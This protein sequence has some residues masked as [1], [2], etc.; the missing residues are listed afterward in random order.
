MKVYITARF[1]GSENKSEIEE[2][3]AAVKA[4]G[5]EDFCF[6]RDVENYQKTFDN[7]KDL[8]ERSKLEI[9]KCDALLI[10]VS[11]SPS[12][13]RVVEVGIAY[14]LGLPIFVIAKSGAEYKGFFD[15]VAT[16]VIRYKKY[17]DI[18][19]PLSKYLED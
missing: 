15:G 5:M 12:G 10:D 2:L 4:A 13:G 9:Q 6:I 11:D 19:A 1:K 16:Q 8:W 18:V 3:C 17:S 14:A 7:P